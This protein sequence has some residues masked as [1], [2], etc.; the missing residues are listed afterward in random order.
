MTLIGTSTGLITGW[1][2]NMVPPDP[3]YPYVVSN[4]GNWSARNAFTKDVSELLVRVSLYHGMENGPGDSDPLQDCSTILGRILGN[5][6]SASPG[7]A[8]T[9]GFHRHTLVLTGGWTG[10]IM[11]CTSTREEHEPGTYHFIQEY[12]LWT[13]K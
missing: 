11:E 4:I 6:S 8:P 9:Y 5:W 12:L 1:Y 3:T 7:T 2:A 13:S 10:S